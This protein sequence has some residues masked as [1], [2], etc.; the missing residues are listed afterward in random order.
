MSKYC[1]R[2]NGI[3]V[4][5][6]AKLFRGRCKM[7][8]C[9]YCSRENKRAWRRAIK[10]AIEKDTE[11]KKSAWVMLTFTMPNWV[12]KDDNGILVS[13]QIIKDNWNKLMMRIKKY[14]SQRD[15]LWAKYNGET[16][17]E[18]KLTY[19]RVL[20][21]H[22]SGILHVHLLINLQLIEPELYM[23]PHRKDDIRLRWLKAYPDESDLQVIETYG[24]GWL[25]H[26]LMLGDDSQYAVN[27]ITK[28]L[29]KDDDTDKSVKFADI[30]RKTKIRRI[31]TSRNIKAPRSENTD[32]WTPRSHLNKDDFIDTESYKDLNLRKDITYSDLDKHG[33]Y[34]PYSEREET[35]ID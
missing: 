24:F 12:H 20:E 18:Q 1:S 30:L 16:Y 32:T 35:Y 13:A 28:Y 6:K 27:Y 3:L 8:D 5:D 14:Y 9:K 26:V 31:Q 7:W 15:K 22:A 17:K 29:T 23:N 33:I 4:S 25:H 19:V 10:R 11:L 34:P 2:Y 21:N